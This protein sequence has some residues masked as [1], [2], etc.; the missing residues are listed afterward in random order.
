MENK[1]ICA[2]WFSAVRFFVI[3]VQYDLYITKEK[4]DLYLTFCRNLAFFQEIAQTGLFFANVAD[5]MST[6]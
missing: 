6:D 2:L 3:N 5:I 1:A 4:Y